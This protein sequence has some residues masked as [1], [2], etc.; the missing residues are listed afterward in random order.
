VALLSVPTEAELENLA[1]TAE[2][3]WIQVARFREPDRGNEL[4][5]IAMGP[6]GKNLVARLPL[7]LRDHRA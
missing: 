5:A 6:Q 4:T 7:T 2:R 1:C 3:K